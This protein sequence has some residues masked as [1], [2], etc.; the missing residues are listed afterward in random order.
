M[1]LT[2]L[3]YW[4]VA[5]S[6]PGCYM[7]TVWY[8]LLPTAERYDLLE[9]THFWV[10]LFYVTWPLNV[11]VY[12]MNDYMDVE[13]DALNPRKGTF[14]F[15]V[16]TSRKNLR[17]VYIVAL[18]TQIPF[19]IYFFSLRGFPIVLWFIGAAAFNI[20][21]NIWPK[22]SDIPPFDLVL[23]LG[24]M[25][26]IPLAMIVNECPA[27]PPLSLFHGMLLT[28]RVQVWTEILDIKCDSKV[29]RVTSMVNIGIN[30]AVIV[31]Y[32]LTFLEMH[33]C[34]TLFK[35]WPLFIFEL[36]S[37]GTVVADFG[38]AALALLVG[39]TAISWASLF[40][41]VWMDSPFLEG[42]HHPILPEW[43]INN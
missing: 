1:R 28:V 33:I 24:Y 4:C 30:N 10:A 3:I 6:R 25:M 31:M 39:A 12:V 9:T 26:A 13:T 38:G 20:C 22:V 5:V 40:F 19:F 36:L 23:P 34:Y 41:L 17:P 2:E 43:P 35:S 8:Y 16:K 32:A 14:W 7:F 15:G 29:K 11:L 42:R 27:L 37:A 21:Y 18:L